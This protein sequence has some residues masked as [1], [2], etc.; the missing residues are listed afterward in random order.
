MGG[1]DEHE[2]STGDQLLVLIQMVDHYRKLRQ[3]TAEEIQLID[4]GKL[5]II[6]HGKDCTQFWKGELRDTLAKIDRL[7]NGFEYLDQ[8][9]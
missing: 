7:L 9:G 5:V 1:M 4:T 3:Q 6:R 8:Q 2:S